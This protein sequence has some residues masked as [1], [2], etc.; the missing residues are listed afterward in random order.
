MISAVS[1]SCVNSEFGFGALI[2]IEVSKEAVNNF[3]SNKSVNNLI[4]SAITLMKSIDPNEIKVKKLVDEVLSNKDVKKILENTNVFVNKLN[5]DDFE[6]IGKESVVIFENLKEISENVKTFTDKLDPSDLKEVKEKIIAGVE[7]IL[8]AGIKIFPK[9][10]SVLKTVN[11]FLKIMNLILGAIFFTVSLS[12]VKKACSFV[13]ESCSSI[14]E[15]FNIGKKERKISNSK[16][17]FKILRNII[18]K[19]DIDSKD[20]E[21]MLTSLLAQMSERTTSDCKLVVLAG[22]KNSVALKEFASLALNKC[23]DDN[24][25]I[26]FEKIKAEKV[27]SEAL[28]SKIQNA[29]EGKGKYANKN[30]LLVLDFSNKSNNFK[31]DPAL[32][33]RYS[34][35]LVEFSQKGACEIAIS[36]LKSIMS[37]IKELSAKSGVNI[38][39]STDLVERAGKAFKGM[40]SADI[41]AEIRKIKDNICHL[42]VPYLS[43]VESNSSSVDDMVDIVI[44]LNENNVFSV[45]K[46]D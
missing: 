18:N 42:L 17:Y 13:V 46:K 33:E 8:S 3:V 44:D 29:L 4:N 27:G 30:G 26:Y 35:Y 16:D 14:K 5:P 6:K 7:E 21:I 10:D 37:E 25:K 23:S 32:K 15:W 1:F 2:G 28:F 41:S 45:H 40:N 43:Q 11:L 31:I 36:E 12:F 20:K 38:I 9:F 22:T 24:F 34:R 19:L 39:L